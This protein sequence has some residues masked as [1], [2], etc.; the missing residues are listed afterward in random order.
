V[1]ARWPALL[2]ALLLPAC[3]GEELGKGAYAS[4]TELSGRGMV[5]PAGLALRAPRTLKAKG[6]CSVRVTL[7]GAKRPEQM[8]PAEFLACTRDPTVIC[9]QDGRQLRLEGEIEDASGGRQPLA[10][11]GT[12]GNLVDLVPRGPAG[13]AAA[14]TS[15]TLR[16]SDVVEV[17]SVVWLDVG[18]R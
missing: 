3:C 1:I 11:E 15:L 2:L 16:S 8:L 13:C 17:E 14:F 9:M 5:T 6:K 18:T 4:T 12:T 7:P 10:S